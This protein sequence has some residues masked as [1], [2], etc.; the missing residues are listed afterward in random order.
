MRPSTILIVALALIANYYTTTFAIWLGHWYSH[1]PRSILHGFHVGGH[2]ALYRD[3][4]HSLSTRFLAGVGRNNS[5]V[6]L[7]PALVVQ[8]ALQFFMLPLWLF[9]VCLAGTGALM[10]AFAHLHEQFHIAGSWL[11]RFRWFHRTRANHLVHHDVEVNFMVAD[12]TWD[13][14]LGTFVSAH[15]RGRGAVAS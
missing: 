5:V 4:A 13:R 3:S 7:A 14:A 12:H 11:E 1:R 15:R 8:Q 6:A 9:A 2:H 10:A